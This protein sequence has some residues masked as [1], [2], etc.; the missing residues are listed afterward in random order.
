MGTKLREL[1]QPFLANR[2]AEIVPPLSGAGA[3]CLDELDRRIR[4]R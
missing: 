4:L 2:E 1:P 3:L